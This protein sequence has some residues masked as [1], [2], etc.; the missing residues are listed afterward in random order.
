MSNLPP[1]SAEER[2]VFLEQAKRTREA[3]QA[4]AEAEYKNDWADEGHWLEL[5]RKFKVRLPLFYKAPTIY[6]LN[7]FARL[8]GDN[9]QLLTGTLFGSATPSKEIALVNSLLPKGE[10][11]NLR[12]YCGWMLE[13]W[14]ELNKTR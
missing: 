1:I 6:Q 12:A 4:F 3:N 2:K 10:R 8:L 11:Y 14:D 5:A 7:K 9:D 13:A